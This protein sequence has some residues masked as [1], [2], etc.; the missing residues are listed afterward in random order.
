[1]LRLRCGAQKRVNERPIVAQ[2]DENA[3]K[4]IKPLKT[5]SLRNAN[6]IVLCLLVRHEHDQGWP[7]T[8]WTRTR[9]REI[10][11]AHSKRMRRTR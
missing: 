8:I 5:Y 4:N 10:D 1:M 2:I 9:T 6:S 11:A 3:N 7:D